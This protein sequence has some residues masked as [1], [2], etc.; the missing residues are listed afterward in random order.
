MNEETNS[1]TDFIVRML[2]WVIEDQ[3]RKPPYIAVISKRQLWFG[4]GNWKKSSDPEL[5][6]GLLKFLGIRI[7]TNIEMEKK[8]LFYGYP[9]LQKPWSFLNNITNAAIRQGIEW[10]TIDNKPYSDIRIIK[11]K[12]YIREDGTLDPEQTQGVSCY[13][14]MYANTIFR[15]DQNKWIKE[16]K[17]W[18]QLQILRNQMTHRELLSEKQKQAS[19]L[20]KNN[21]KLLAMLEYKELVLPIDRTKIT[22][23]TEE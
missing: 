9:A 20:V 15:K 10:L 1:P 18:I 3:I 13:V 19:T 2:N 6:D 16:Q 11:G 8:N 21:R 23:N 7:P 5:K 4:N 22:W 12:G 17:D 14:L